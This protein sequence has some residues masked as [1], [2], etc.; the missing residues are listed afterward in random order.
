MQVYDAT[1]G[2]FLF[3]WQ[4]R[5]DGGTFLL[6]LDEAENIEVIAARPTKI[7]TYSQ[8]GVFGGSRPLVGSFWNHKPSLCDMSAGI[9]VC[10]SRQF[11]FLP[12]LVVNRGRER[13][14]VSQGPLTWSLGAPLP[15]L[16]FILLAVAVS[17]RT[18]SK[19]GVASVALMAAIGCGPTA[20]VEA[21]GQRSMA[22]AARL[23]DRRAVL[24]ALYDPAANA[25]GV[26]GEEREVLDAAL[27]AIQE[28]MGS[29]TSSSL[30]QERGVY[31][32]VGVEPRS[33]QDW[34]WC[35]STHSVSVGGRFASAGVGRVR[36][37]YCTSGEAPALRAVDFG[38]PAGNVGGLAKVANA[39]RRLWSVLST[40]QRS[41]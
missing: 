5:V 30:I 38:V 27:R 3:G 6:D 21:L 18:V 41:R 7:L 22:L 40:Q 8:E 25:S 1:T 29:F 35:R 15:A 16:A 19:R 31:R 10:F 20:E 4:P 12:Q 28:E 9:R 14:V 23:N 11:G 36:F 34:Q 13:A 24:D 2:R 33:P 17:L 39:Q 26:R 32:L 37:I